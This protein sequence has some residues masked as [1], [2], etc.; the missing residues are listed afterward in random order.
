MKYNN[1]PKF[2]TYFVA[3]LSFFLFDPS[4]LLFLLKFSFKQTFEFLFTQCDLYIHC[5]ILK[6]FFTVLASLNWASSF[7]GSL[8]KI[9]LPHRH[10]KVGLPEP[11][12]APQ[13][14]PC[15]AWCR[16]CTHCHGT[17]SM[18]SDN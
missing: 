16:V 15:L 4:F 17:Q 5:L 3:P 18:L 11:K 12:P 13:L 6:A 7:Q 14:L 1:V 8:S 2:R 9:V 10:S